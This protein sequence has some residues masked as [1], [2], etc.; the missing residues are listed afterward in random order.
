MNIEKTH[1]E[2]RGKSL[3][4]V[5]TTP[6]RESLWQC[7]RDPKRAGLIKQRGGSGNIRVKVIWWL[8]RLVNFVTAN[9][10]SSP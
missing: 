2:K 5:L 8:L 9:R 3:S 4:L 1:K 7:W 6:G 10:D